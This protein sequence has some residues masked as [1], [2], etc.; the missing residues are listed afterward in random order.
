MK[1]GA[2]SAA[3][4]QICS[5]IPFLVAPQTAENQNSMD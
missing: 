4:T 3:A 2:M 5:A 1:N